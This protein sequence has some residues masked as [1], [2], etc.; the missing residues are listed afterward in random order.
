MFPETQEALFNAASPRAIRPAAPP[1]AL[2]PREQQVLNLMAKGFSHVE[3]ARLQQ[4]SVNTT[5]TQAKNI[6]SK[7]NVHSRSEA[8]FEAAVLGLLE[9]ALWSS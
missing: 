5:R 6:Y 3:I 4:V 2:T 7:L 8:V 9:P 1:V